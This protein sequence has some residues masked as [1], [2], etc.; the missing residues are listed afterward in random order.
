VATTRGS[1]SAAD[2]AAGIERKKPLRKTALITGASSGIGAEFARQLAPEYDLLLVAR[3]EDRLNALQSHLASVHPEGVFRTH[4]TDLATPTGV[5]KLIDAV[6]DD[7]DVVVDLLINNAGVGSHGPFI[8]E[9]PTDVLAQVQLNCVCLIALTRALLPAM[10]DRGHGGVINVASTAAFQPTPTMAV[11]GATKA[12]VLSFSEALSVET[13]RTGVDVLALCPGATETGFFAATGRDFL[14]TGRQTP[15]Q[16]VA[17]AM[18][19]L[20]RHRPV[21]VSGPTNKVKAQGYRFMPRSLL[22]R[23]SATVVRDRG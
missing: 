6:R 2:A 4:V 19:A 21:V 5:Q 7:D 17:T 23:A 16:V 13:R 3:S 20:R 9:S 10:V 11:Y 15:S 12:F 14:T 22:A 1:C 18:Q 8:T